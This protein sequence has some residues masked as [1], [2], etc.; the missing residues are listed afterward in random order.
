MADLE[1]AER[2]KGLR[3]ER[4]LTQQE[5]A[6]VQDITLRAYQR[7]EAGGGLKAENAKALADFYG[8]ELKWLLHGEAP[9]LLGSLNGSRPAE[10]AAIREQL[11][12]IQECN[13]VIVAV[14]RELA[15]T[16]GSE[17][18]AALAEAQSLVLQSQGIGAPTPAGR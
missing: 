11:Q 9:D 8:V 4:G 12:Q 7:Q 2:I 3:E 1:R 16:V 15:A 18:G 10:L 6:D 17:Q 5:V 14:L 13:A